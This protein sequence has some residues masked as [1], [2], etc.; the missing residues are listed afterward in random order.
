MVG[1]TEK[2]AH[3][4]SRSACPLPA[5]LRERLDGELVVWLSS[6]RPDGAPH[7][8]PLWFAW[9]GEAITIYSKPEA[10]KVRNVRRDPR[11]MVAVGQAGSAFTVTLLEGV[12]E[13]VEGP[14]E[15]S[16]ES[17]RLARYR[18]AMRQLG[19]GVEDFLATYSQRIR[20]QPVR[21]LD[22]G[23]PDWRA[24]VAAAR[25]PDAQVERVTVASP[26]LTAVAT[27]A[28]IFR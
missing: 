19:I 8:L 7:L 26:F 15:P 16:A 18:D 6:V 5:E 12:A 21:V 10:Q 24:A 4:G 11:V 23:M 27:G 3:R 13:V 9:D 20:I 28:A 25:S 2:F 14:G 17:G 22:W 1:Q